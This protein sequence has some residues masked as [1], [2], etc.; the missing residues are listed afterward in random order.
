ME[1]D[2]NAKMAAPVRNGGLFHF[3]R[4]GT[5]F[6]EELKD[7]KSWNREWT[8][9]MRD[10]YYGLVTTGKPRTIASVHIYFL[11]YC[12]VWHVHW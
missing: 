3:S 1:N 11:V 12:V 5:K 8:E 10:T 7:K 6:A 4:Y 2:G 9:E